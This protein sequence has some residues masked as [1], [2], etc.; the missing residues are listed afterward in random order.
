MK[1][2]SL[3]IL[4]QLFLFSLP[5]FSQKDI[6]L[7]EVYLNDGSFIRGEIVEKVEDQYIRIKITGGNIVQF[8]MT[9]IKKIGKQKNSFHY[10]SNGNKIKTEGYY[11]TVLGGIIIEKNSY[12]N[13]YSG[14][15]NLSAGYKMNKIWGLGLGVSFDN[16]N[17]EFV[18]LFAETRIYPVIGK[19]SPY[20]SGKFGYGFPVDFLYDYN[21][22]N[23]SNGTFLNPSLGFQFYS[24]SNNSFV[25][26]VGY[27]FQKTQRNIEWQQAKDDIIFRRINISLGIQF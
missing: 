2:I 25:V 22:Q 27:K 15:L 9:E 14:S 1:K 7:D 16:Y 13:R 21:A 17:P 20:L 19:I 11:L 5:T 6:K 23:Y 18:S 4:L 12:Q 10:F 3:L 8:S 26:E 24:R